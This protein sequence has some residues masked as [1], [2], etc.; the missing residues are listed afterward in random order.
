ML[1]SIVVDAFLMAT[2]TIGHEQPY[3][4]AL[5]QGQ[6]CNYLGY[7]IATSSALSIT[8]RSYLDAGYH[9]SGSLRLTDA[10]AIHSWLKWA[11]PDDGWHCFDFQNEIAIQSFL[12]SFGGDDDALRSECIAELKKA[13]KESAIAHVT[14]GVTYGYDP[15]DFQRSVVGIYGKHGHN[16][17]LNEFSMMRRL[18]ADIKRA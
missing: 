18:D 13:S 1:A 10:E 4:F 5:V 12:Q 3:A 9:Y 15:A 14:L 7:A 8:A 6:Q 16:R 17:C 11:N 2:E